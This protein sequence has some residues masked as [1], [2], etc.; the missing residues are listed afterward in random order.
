VLGVLLI[1]L[2]LL[3]VSSYYNTLNLWLGTLLP[4]GA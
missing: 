2:G 3:M 4:P 1:L